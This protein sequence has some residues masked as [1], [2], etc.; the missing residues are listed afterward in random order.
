MTVTRFRK[1]VSRARESMPREEGGE[2]GQALVEAQAGRADEHWAIQHGASRRQRPGH[3][4][5]QA[6]PSFFGERVFWA[7]VTTTTSTGVDPAKFHCS[8]QCRIHR[9]RSS[10]WTRNLRMLKLWGR[11]NSINVQK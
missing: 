4:W 10:V 7:N 3:V 5:T 2:V 1:G 6:P 11:T 8:T 9:G